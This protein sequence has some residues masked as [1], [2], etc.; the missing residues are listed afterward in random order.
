[1]HL[2]QKRIFLLCL[3]GALLF[4]VLTFCNGCQN[5]QKPQ[6]D[7]AT[8]EKTSVKSEP[9]IS[10]KPLTIAF[11]SV[12]SPQTTRQS[13]QKIVDILSK[14]LN[15]PVVLIQRKTY[16]ELNTLLESGEADIAFLSTGAYASYRGVEP[17]ELLAMIKTRGTVLYET[18]LI[19]PVDSDAKNFSDLRDK[20]FAFTDPYSYSGRLAVDNYLLK[21]NITA[22]DYFSDFFYTYNHDKSI[23][24]VAN[25]LADGASI[26]SQIYDYEIAK[27][28]DLANKVKILAILA[29]AP[30]GPV[31]IRKDLPDKEHIKQVFFSLNDDPEAKEAMQS[32]IIDEF[33]PPQES[34]YEPLRK[35]YDRFYELTRK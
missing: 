19:V 4:G 3:M 8:V 28:K 31:V 22:K 17:I 27:N 13:Y 20:K 11:A 29:Q 12:M 35:N 18:Y 34:L 32:V 23:W 9:H 21:Q 1:M 16:K 15:R 10:A 2:Q 25:H 5:Q 7:F 26:D 30:T 24:V 6:I 33:V 14:K